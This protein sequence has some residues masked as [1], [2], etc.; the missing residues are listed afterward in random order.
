MSES[1]LCFGGA[2]IFSLR[3]S[4]QKIFEG[5]PWE[6]R[7]ADRGAFGECKVPFAADLVADA[8]VGLAGRSG[9]I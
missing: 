2:L 9:D 1:G 8:A 7:V 3:M 5:Q 4:G 6:K